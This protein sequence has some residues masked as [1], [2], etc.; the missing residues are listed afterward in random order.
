MYIMVNML[1]AAYFK[2][3]GKFKSYSNENR[4]LLHG[5]FLQAERDGQNVDSKLPTLLTTLNPQSA[6]KLSFTRLDLL[7]IKQQKIFLF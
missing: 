4:G 6:S 5:D 1:L 7:R 2:R 3:S